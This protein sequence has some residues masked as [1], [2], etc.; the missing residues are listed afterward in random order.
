MTPK[1]ELSW[2][3]KEKGGSKTSRESTVVLTSGA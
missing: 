1:R 3:K 2:Q